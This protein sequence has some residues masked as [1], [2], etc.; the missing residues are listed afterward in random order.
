MSKISRILKIDPEDR[1]CCTGYAVISPKSREVREGE[2]SAKKFEEYL[3]VLFSHMKADRYIELGLPLFTGLAD[4][5]KL[6]RVMAVDAANACAYV[7]DFRLEED[8]EVRAI[9]VKVGFA[10][11]K[12]D[13]AKSLVYGGSAVFAARTLVDCDDK[14]KFATVDIEHKFKIFK[15]DKSD[16]AEPSHP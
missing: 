16:S 3:A 2:V 15:N 1:N 11:P 6:M 14:L 5:D 4:Q 8:D 9:F 12:S 10:G 13:L 7:K